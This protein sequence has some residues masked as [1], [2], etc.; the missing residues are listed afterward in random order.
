M[1][2]PL[3]GLCVAVFVYDMLFLR[4]PNRLLLLAL[5]VQAAALLLTGRGI[6]GVDAMQSLMGGVIGLFLFVPLY[7]LRAMGAGD[8]KFFAVLGL[9]LG[10]GYMIPLWLIGSLLAGLHA[11]ALYLSRRGMI[12][13]PLGLQQLV[14]RIADSAAYRRLLSGRQG[15]QGIPYAAYLAVAAMAAVTTTGCGDL[16]MH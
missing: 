1:T 4:V 7:A 10:P 8:V 6:G 2:L 14:L 5:T 3:F 12:V 13:L 16:Q 15:R 11:V 9:L